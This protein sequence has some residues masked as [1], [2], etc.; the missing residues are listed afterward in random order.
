MMPISGSSTSAASSGSGSSARMPA[1]VSPSV[2]HT[3]AI[4]PMRAPMKA[5]TSLPAAPPANTSVS[6]KPDGRQARALGHQQNGRKIRKPM[7]V[8]LS[9]MPIDSSTGKPKRLVRPP[10]M[11]AGLRHRAGHR[12][13]LDRQARRQPIDRN[14]RD[15]PASSKQRQ[16]RLPRHH[17]QQQRGGGRHRHLADVAGEVVGAERL[18]RARAGKGAGHQR[19]RERVLRAGAEPPDQQRDHQRPDADAGARDQIADPGQRRCRAP[20]PAARRTAR[21]PAMREFETPPWCRNSRCAR[22]RAPRS[23]CRTRPARAAA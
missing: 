10:S 21:Q 8:A 9:I 4:T 18:Q 3:V 17:H 5:Q 23:R 14:G 19:R 7:R 22:V 15:K 1:V 13:S 11:A 6:A 2:R 16:H 20:A 12:G